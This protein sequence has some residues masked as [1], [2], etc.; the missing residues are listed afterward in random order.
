MEEQIFHHT[1]ANGLTLV[2]QPMPWLESAAF[3]IAVPA[4]HRYDPDGKHGLAN[5]ACEMVQRGCGEL[6]SREYIEALEALG[7]DYSSSASLYN[8]NY[9]GAMQAAQL[10]EALGIFADVLQ[11]PTFPDDQLEDGR[12]VCFQ[13]IA[14]LGDDLAQR[15]LQRLRENFYGATEGRNTE[16][17]LESVGAI[18]LDDIKQFYQTNYRPNGLIIAC[19]GKLDW[20]ALKAHVGELFD[21]WNK[22]PE[23]SV[24]LASPVHGNDHIQHESEQTHIAIAYPGVAYSH[25]DYY[26]NRGAIGVLSGGMSSRLFT[27]VREKRGLCYTVFASCNTLKDKGAV[28]CYSGTTN[29]RAQETLDVIIEELQKLAEGIKEDELRR[30]KVQIRSGMVMQQESCRGRAGSIAGDWFHLGRVRTLDE[31]TDKIN[32]LTVESINEYLAANPPRNFDIVTLGPQP[33]EFNENG[34]SATQA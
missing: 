3:S 26:L 6:N 31:V 15:T 17:T 18:T 32:G 10:H 29:E 20:E 22:K 7:V 12:M 23:P 4:G 34:I 16:G 11:R 5:F 8:T 19:A 33:L 30:L 24:E 13:E 28:L 2:G 21:G 27:E 25:E 14:A 1:Y 9:S